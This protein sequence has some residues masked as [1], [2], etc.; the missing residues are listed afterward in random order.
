MAP[1]CAD[2][3]AHAQ[4][5]TLPRTPSAQPK[6]ARLPA[7]RA[8]AGNVALAGKAPGNGAADRIA[9]AAGAGITPSGFGGFDGEAEAVAADQLDRGPV[10]ARQAAS[11]KLDGQQTE[12]A[13]FVPLMRRR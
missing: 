12:G 10:Q 9:R 1:A 8:D 11:A 3:R 13:E 2:E 6:P 4:A 7:V 5:K